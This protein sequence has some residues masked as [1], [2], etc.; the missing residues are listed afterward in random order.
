MGEVGDVLLIPSA[1]DL[2]VV[3]EVCTTHCLALTWKLICRDY[4]V[5]ERDSKSDAEL[6][7]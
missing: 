3:S 7:M 1:S 4:G 5:S 2:A 6:E